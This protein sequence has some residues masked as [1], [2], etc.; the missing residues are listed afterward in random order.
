M[1]TCDNN[2]MK[3][4]KFNIANQWNSTQQGKGKY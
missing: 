3:K 4:Y 2:K 1:N